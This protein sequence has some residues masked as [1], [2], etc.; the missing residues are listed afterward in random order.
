MSKSNA[1]YFPS[2]EAY[3]ISNE[4]TVEDSTAIIQVKAMPAGTCLYVEYYF[5]DECDGCWQPFNLECCQLKLCGCQNTFYF[6]FHGKF[7][8]IAID[9]DG[10]HLTDTSYYEN[11]EIQITKIKDEN[12]DLSSY[13]PRCKSSLEMISDIFVNDTAICDL[14]TNR[15]TN[16]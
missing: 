9:E 8:L 14:I 15:L 13:Y 7:R 11:M 10:N 16:N 2:E 6:P 12:K 5:G 1:E 3:N 4:F